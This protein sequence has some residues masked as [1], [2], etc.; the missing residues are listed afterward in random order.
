MSSFCNTLWCKSKQI[1]DA[2]SLILDE[3]LAQTGII[4]LVDQFKRVVRGRARNGFV[5]Y[6]SSIEHPATSI[7]EPRRPALALGPQ[8]DLSSLLSRVW[9][10]GEG[11]VG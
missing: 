2:G 10:R 1:L 8:I 7:A 5:C 9:A 6:L 4:G 3:T 11:R